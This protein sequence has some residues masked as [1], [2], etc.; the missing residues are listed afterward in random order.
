MWRKKNVSNRQTDLDIKLIPT[1]VTKRT[2]LIPFATTGLG[3]CVQSLYLWYK[4]N[5]QPYCNVYQL[6]RY[7][8]VQFELH[9]FM[10]HQKASNCYPFTNWMFYFDENYISVMKGFFE[11]FKMLVCM[12]ESYGT[13][14]LAEYDYMTVIPT[15]QNAPE[16]ITF[17][18]LR[19]YC[20]EWGNTTNSIKMSSNAIPGVIVKDGYLING[21]QIMP[22]NYT[23][24]DLVDDCYDVL[25]AL[26]AFK[27]K[28]DACFPACTYSGAGKPSV[29][30]TTN[31]KE[32][33]DC[34]TPIP[35]PERVDQL[36]SPGIQPAMWKRPRRHEV[37]NHLFRL[38]V[39]S[40]S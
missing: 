26:E 16:C 28:Y 22:N 1:N 29:F 10:A 7:I 34:V 19:Q 9:R 40:D 38:T 27:S 20:V 6:Y 17:S 18:T 32:V 36:E 11:N 31:A 15:I 2:L 21:D 30:V 8:L 39:Q 35:A 14:R 5:L 33:Q 4:P 12:I 37:A 23:H 3:F 25:Q 24:N 13:F